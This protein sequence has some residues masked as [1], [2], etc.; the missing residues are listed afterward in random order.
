[1]YR[2][3]YTVKP[4]RGRRKTSWGS[5]V[6]PVWGACMR[7]HRTGGCAGAFASAGALSRNARVVWERSHRQVA[8]VKTAGGCCIPPALRGGLRKGVRIAGGAAQRCSCRAGAFSLAGGGHEYSD[9]VRIAPPGRSR[10]TGAVCVF[11]FIGGGGRSITLG[12]VRIAALTVNSG[13]RG[14]ARIAV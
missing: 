3:K 13:H 10:R 7:S 11:V 12:C 1:M 6:K 5:S 8:A 2:N 9:G 4:S 14:C